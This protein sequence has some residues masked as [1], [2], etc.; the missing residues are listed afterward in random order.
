MKAS[1]VLD[2]NPTCRY[3]WAA[4]IDVLLARDQLIPISVSSSIPLLENQLTSSSRLSFAVPAAII[5]DGGS[6]RWKYAARVKSGI[7]GCKQSELFPYSS[8]HPRITDPAV[9]AQRS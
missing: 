5:V 9:H 7:M 6:L 2:I 1:G 8:V 4:C 3:R